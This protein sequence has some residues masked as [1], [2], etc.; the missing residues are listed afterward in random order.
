MTMKI[1]IA[2]ALFQAFPGY[3]RHVVLAEDLDNSGGPEQHPRLEALLREREAAV[4]A[5]DAYLDK[6][7]GD[8]Q[9]GYATGSETY[10][11][12]GRPEAE[13]HPLPGEV[14]L[15]DTGNQDVFCRAWCWKNGH[16]SRIEATT[17]RVLIN[18][19]TL[20]PVPAETGQAAAREVAELV[21]AACGGRC[22]IERLDAARSEL[23]A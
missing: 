20:P 19:D 2:P 18:L 4:R 9:L 8:V 15:L 14:V 11:P 10:R 13:E 1:R 17:R 23:E 5:D 6:V 7:V 16:L 3:V 12:L 22:R 21:A